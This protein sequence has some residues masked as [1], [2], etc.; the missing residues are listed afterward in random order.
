MR[1]F[2]ENFAR[3]A[4]AARGIRGASRR[5]A[6]GRPP[7]GAPLAPR[8][9][10]WLPYGR[11]WSVAS[12]GLSA[13]RPQP[14]RSSSA[15]LPLNPSG[16]CCGATLRAAHALALAL[17]SLGVAAGFAPSG[18]IGPYGAPRVAASGRSA[19]GAFSLPPY[20]GRWRPGW[21]AF[22]FH[23]PLPA[24][25]RAT[26]ALTGGLSTPPNPPMSWVG[27]ASGRQS[28][29]K[30]SKE[31]RSKKEKEAALTSVFFLF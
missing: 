1:E 8:A 9:S 24:S 15:L 5:S 20:G 4:S 14:R 18:R 27:T 11:P 6:G 3:F 13:T 7:P 17:C 29:V 21:V 12:R 26:L 31:K 10:P 30:K 19:G 22:R 25:G 28:V 16:R 23:P 2:R